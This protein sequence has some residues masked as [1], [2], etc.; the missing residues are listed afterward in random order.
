[1]ERALG[2]LD[3]QIV[4]L[5]DQ[6]YQVLRAPMTGRI[7]RLTTALGAM[8]E[9][10]L[11]LASIVPENARLE[12][13]LYVPSS[14]AGFVHIGTKVR[15][16]YDA[17]PYQKFGAQTAKVTSISRTAVN[18]RELPFPVQTDEP[19]YLV[20]A[21][22]DKP[23]VSAFGHDEPLTP[24]SKFQADLVLENRRIWEWV[25]EPLLAV[26]GSAGA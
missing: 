11:P 8:A 4:Q 26:R 20:T 16:R 19:L 22:I 18:G 13:S 15:L 24:G 5:A 21:A 1:M 23:V 2:E 10:G 12:A 9:A 3:Q 25:I 6:H 7:T 14:S 17:F